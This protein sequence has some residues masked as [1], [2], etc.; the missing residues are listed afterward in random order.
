MASLLEVRQI[1]K[2]FGGV[3]AVDELSFAI[4][5][6]G[7][8]AIIGPNGSGK[9]TCINLIT[10]CYRLTGGE[11]SFGGKRIDGLSRE[12]IVQ[13]GLARTFQN[14][15]LF[16]TLTVLDHVL[17][18]QFLHCRVEFLRTILGSRAAKRENREALERSWEL[19]ELV[20]LQDKADMLAKSLPY[21][22]RRLLEIARALATRPKLLF[23]DEPAAGMSEEEIDR[24]IDLV[25]TI[26]KRGMTILL[27]EHRM[28]LVMN[29]AEHII[30]L[31]Y[32]KKIAE[33]SAGEIQDNQDVVTA[34]LGTQ[35]EK[36][37]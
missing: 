13:T 35:H 16:E 36:V 30:V 4:P 27:I 22:P 21:G 12:R 3:R 18:G 24:V 20:G 32:G 1:S 17:M 26:Q 31:N 15:R 6:G 8:Q 25:R 29:V 2:H 7:L 14:L 33:G 34:Y 37:G 19:L 23:L 28:R 11:V 5:E 10:G 9:T